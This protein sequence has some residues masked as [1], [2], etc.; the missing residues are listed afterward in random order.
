MKNSKKNIIVFFWLSFFVATLPVAA[1][2]NDPLSL[3]PAFAHLT[4]RYNHNHLPKS[5]H[6]KI[7]QPRT[8]AEQ[9]EWTILILIQAS[10]NL[11]SFAYTNMK[12]MMKWGSTEKVNILIDLHK[13][14]DKSWK[15]KIEQG[16]YTVEEVSA[17]STESTIEKEVFE[18]AQ[19]AI[20]HYPAKKYGL[21]FWNHG[22]GC[23]DP[24]QKDNKPSYL[25]AYD[26]NWR[27]IEPTNNYPESSRAL[28]NIIPADRGILFDDERQT[29]LSNQGLRNTLNKI[30]SELLHFQKI[31][32]IGMDACLMGML[33]IA[34]QIKEYAEY[35]VASEEFEFAQGWP[36]GAIIEH[37]VTTPTISS[38]EIASFIVAAYERYYNNKTSYYTQS[39]TDLAK[40]PALKE[41]IDLL[42][43]HL[44]TIKTQDP[45][46]MKLF[47]QQARSQA[48]SF[49]LADY[50]DLQSLYQELLK[51]TNYAIEQPFN[52]NTPTPQ[53]DKASWI[54]LRNILVTGLDLVK[55]TVTANVAGR[56]LSRAGGLA[57]Y[58]P[59]KSMDPS[60]LLTEMAKTTSWGGFVVEQLLSK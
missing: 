35:F 21:V 32:F 30:H 52:K 17:R 9:A 48:L 53:I 14:G 47:I 39:C 42:A 2:N 11:E 25:S 7:G 10:N 8:T 46:R 5:E 29:Y 41:N 18:S 24:K 40:I 27:G 33:E 6:P 28:R 16:A 56:Y 60:Y 49:S 19:W 45:A 26:S 4:R 43:Q 36:Y 15:Y 22:I 50:V 55:N 38:K 23:I 44:A 58:F 54:T 12:E 59:Q 31:G 13:T 3:S 1:T 20:T 51:L 57:I 37:L 34:D